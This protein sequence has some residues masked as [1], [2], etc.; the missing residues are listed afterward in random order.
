MH[1]INCLVFVLYQLFCVHCIN[2]ALY[3]SSVCTLHQLY[4]LYQLSVC[5]V[6]TVCVYCINCLYCINGVFVLYQLSVCIVSTV[7]CVNCLCACINFL[8]I[9]STVCLSVYCIN[10][11]F[12]R[13]FASTL[14]ISM[15]VIL[16]MPLTKTYTNHESEQTPGNKLYPTR[17]PFS[18]IIYLLV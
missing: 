2:C 7:Y 5:I 8:C 16:D 18:C 15:L 14:V 9:V 6:S 4:A 3:Q 12:L 11:G 10:C 1:C 13:F 17:L